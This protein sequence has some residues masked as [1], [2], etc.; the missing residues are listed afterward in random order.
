MFHY[1]IVFLA[2]VNEITIGCG[3][4]LVQEIDFVNLSSG[5]RFTQNTKY[6]L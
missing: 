5:M 3:V 1:A 4:I 6:I 2:S